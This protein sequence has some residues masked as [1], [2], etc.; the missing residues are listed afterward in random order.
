M[1]FAY[2]PPS[3]SPQAPA[4]ANQAPATPAAPASSGVNPMLAYQ[5]QNITTAKN[6]AEFS[7]LLP[8]NIMKDATKSNKNG[9]DWISWRDATYILE[10]KNVEYKPPTPGKPNPTPLIQAKFQVLANDDGQGNIGDTPLGEVEHAFFMNNP[11]FGE[12]SGD[13]ISAVYNT[14]NDLP[15]L[16]GEATL[17]TQPIRGRFV[18]AVVGGNRSKKVHKDDGALPPDW[19]RCYSEVRFFPIDVVKAPDGSI[20]SVSQPDDARGG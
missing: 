18:L 15:M 20:E 14:S 8:A 6:Q 11:K 9:H 16:M 4:A 5:L 2:K 10:I 1:A 7:R 12:Q 13:F 3:T 19:R 17:P